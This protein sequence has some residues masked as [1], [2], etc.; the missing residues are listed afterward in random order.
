MKT[1]VHLL[2]A[3]FLTVPLPRELRCRYGPWLVL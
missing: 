1:L 3:V 2:G